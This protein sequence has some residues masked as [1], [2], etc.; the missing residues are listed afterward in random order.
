MR[1]PAGV[2]CDPSG[3]APGRGAYLCQNPRCWE[4]AIQ[5]RVLDRAL[6]TKLTTEERIA[7]RFEIESRKT[8]DLT[9][10]SKKTETL[11]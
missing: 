4:N 3:K 1:T 7:L 5:N 10:R 6:K 9:P 2:R 11:N 8:T